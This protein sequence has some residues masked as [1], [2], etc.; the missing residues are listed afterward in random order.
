MSKAKVR[1]VPEG[2]HTITP[3]LVIHGAKEAIAFYKKALGATEVMRMPAEDGKRLMHAQLT[4]T[5]L[6]GRFHDTVIKQTIQ[7]R[8]SHQLWCYAQE[9]HAEATW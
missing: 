9:T 7:W 5:N 3:H 6:C 8:R 4:A 2:H 1:A